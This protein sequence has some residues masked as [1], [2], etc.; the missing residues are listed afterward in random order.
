MRTTT[1]QGSVVS[2]KTNQHLEHREEVTHVI[3]NK[4]INRNRAQSENSGKKY[5]NSVTSNG[6][7]VCG[8]SLFIR[9]QRAIQATVLRL[10]IICNFEALKI[11]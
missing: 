9:K 4:L 3:G 1:K 11:F 7:M 8:D 6:K 2:S 10:V 5:L